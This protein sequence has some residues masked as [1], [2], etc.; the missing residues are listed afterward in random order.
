MI[1]EWTSSWNPFNSAK[2]LIH[3]EHLEACVTKE[4]LPPITVSLDPSNVC[5]F[6]CIWCNAFEIMQKNNR[7]ISEDHLIKLADF[8]ADWGIKSVCIAGGGEPFMNPGT[9]NLLYR[10]KEN[11]VG[12]AAVT[13]G[14]LLDGESIDAISRT[15]RWAGFSMDAGCNET[16]LKVKGISSRKMF[17]IVTNNI[18]KLTSKIRD[19]NSSCEVGYKF[20]LHPFNALEIFEAAKLAKSLGVH[21]F[22]LRPVGWDNLSKTEG[23]LNFDKLID[24]VNEQLEKARSLET[25]DFFVYGIRHKFGEKF[26]RKVRFNNCVASPLATLVFGADGNCNICI[27]HRGQ[28]EFVL[29]SHYPNPDN[30]LKFWGSQAHVKILESIDPNECPRCTICSYN[31]IVEQAFIEDKMCKDFI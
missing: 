10:L 19:T 25:D 15:C 12:C 23:S 14:S 8:F 7:M 2:V 4:F 21:D 31:E 13:N 3:R 11:E 26:E 24:K 9:N 20:L 18:E 16:Y 30:I 6:D 28:D 17:K 29:C 27:D 1:K 5:N 22:Q